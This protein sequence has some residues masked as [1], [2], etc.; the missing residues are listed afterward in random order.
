MET[1]KI[2]IWHFQRLISRRL[3]AWAG[4]SIVS[5]V[6]MYLSKNKFWRNV[7]AQFASWGIFNAGIAVFG[8]IS[9]QNRIATIENPGEPDVLASETKKLRLILLINAGLDVLYI[10]GGRGLAQRDTGD[11]AQRG[12]GMG[13]IV[14]GAFLLIFDI[15]HAALIRDKKS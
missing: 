4:I 1:N 7:G 3:L 2:T 6:L 13:I 15:V 12:H 8:N 14:Q 11:G 10:L 9:T 5:G